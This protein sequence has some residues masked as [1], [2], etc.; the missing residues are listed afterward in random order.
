M[1]TSLVH[2]IVWAKEFLLA[3]LFGEAVEEPSYPEDIDPDLLASLKMETEAFADLRRMA[4]EGEDAYARTVAHKVFNQD[5]QKLAELPDLW[6][7]KQPPTPLNVDAGLR[8]EDLA[9]PPVARADD[10]CLWTVPEWLRVFEESIDALRRRA[11]G[12]EGGAVVP[13]Y[14]DKDDESVM[15][16]VAAAAN[17]RASIFGLPMASRFHLK[18]MAGN[19]IPAIA[20]TNAIVAGMMVLQAENVLRGR[21]ER[22]RT[23]FI[24]YG[25]QRSSLFAC[26]CL[27]PPNRDCPVCHLDR[28]V[29]R[30]NPSQVTLRQL[31]EALVRRYSE[32]LEGAP[33]SLED[34]TVI[35][36]SRIL[37]DEDLTANLDKRLLD[38][39]C[40]ECS[41]LK[42]DFVPLTIPIL[43]AIDAAATDR[44]PHQDHQEETIQLAFTLLPPHRRNAPPAQAGD[45]ASDDDDT[46]LEPPAKMSRIS[47]EDDHNADGKVV[48]L[49]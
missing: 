16:F 19:I 5:I 29:A 22:C 40:G 18:S 35:E 41:L 46:V 43:V 48:L 7:H 3:N 23:A 36:G 12:Q 4:R 32:L 24:T 15:D 44:L 13:V 1:P 28:A 6:E 9:D 26:E 30:L 39:G 47:L 10:H 2:C 33:L 20:T 25:G 27:S 37:Y 21:H 17:L 38:I 11:H 14:F 42:L 45:D 34:A 49:L 8:R 31:L